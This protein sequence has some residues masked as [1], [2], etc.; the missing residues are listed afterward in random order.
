MIMIMS[1]KQNN[2]KNEFES[3]LSKDTSDFDRTIASEMFDF[4]YEKGCFDEVDVKKNK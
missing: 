4:L 3:C 1:K 2:L